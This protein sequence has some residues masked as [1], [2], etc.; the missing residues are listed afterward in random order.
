M[1]GIN[2]IYNLSNNIIDIKQN[3]LKMNKLLKH[4]GPDGDNIW[5]KNN[6]GFG[7][8]RL[9]IIDLTDNASQ[10]MTVNNYT[11]TFNGEIYNYKK[12]KDE[13]NYWNFQSNSDTE[14]IIA[15]YSKYNE[16]CVDYLVGMFSFTIWDHNNN[17][18]FCARD[19]FGIKP[20]YY[21]FQDNIFY[22]ASEVKALLP[23]LNKLEEDIDGI[24][25]YLIFQYSISN[26]IMIKHIKQLL[27]AH[28]LIIENNMIN[29][30]KY[31]E[32]DYNNKIELTEEEYCKK[33]KELIDESINLHLVSD[34]PISSYISGGLD[35][36]IITLLAS[37]NIKLN[38]L[39]HGN[40]VE[41]PNCDESYYAKIIANQIDI[42]IKIKNI[43][44]DDFKDNIKKIIYYL[45]YP[46]A[47]PGSF[48]QY[49]IS[50]LAS[51]YTK[52]ILGGQGAD[53][54]FGGYVRYL[55]PYL[56]KCI[57]DSINNENNNL[58]K[59]I[60][61]MKILNEY[62]SMIKHFFSKN[63]FGKLDEQYFF[64]INRANE[65]NDVINWEY[66]SKEKIYDLYKKKF[67]NS[68][69]PETDYFNKMLHF[70]LEY[71]LPGLLHVEDRVSMA[72]G[73]ESRVPFINHNIIE[74][75]SKIPEQNKINYGDTKHLLKKTFN[76]LLP[77]EIKDRKDKMGFPVPL[78]EWFKNE[79]KDFFIETMK[80]LKNRKVKFLNINED[81][82]NNINTNSIFT[83]KYWILF[84]LEL[85]YQNYFDI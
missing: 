27:P 12:L 74:F 19:R 49:M 34:V 52:V 39:F 60:P 77:N 76:E 45:D 66:L 5:I 58:L 20:F 62:K 85:W 79:L 24:T 67:N 28:N 38:Y 29:I 75:I 51:K 31:W 43:N 80:S 83:R 47:G 65:L 35:S 2:G 70:D 36:S 25:E 48:C 44:Y 26:N 46:I 71:S 6:I 64:L 54:L 40:F 16:K 41:Y 8:V 59:L 30:N 69:I 56:D 72:C 17:K 42:D 53:E 32:L 33:I 22:F 1:C 50:L 84:S 73:I 55:I 78:N 13:I 14:V 9:S 68:K 7:H 10:P 15:L 11:I 4:R 37:K 21:L 61:N 82:I 81:F 63:M 3:L 57:N 18:L 23:F